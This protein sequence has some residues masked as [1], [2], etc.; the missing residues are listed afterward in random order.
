MVDFCNPG[1]LGAP[2][3]VRLSVQQAHA[4]PFEP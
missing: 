4:G 3:Q 1:V 2:A